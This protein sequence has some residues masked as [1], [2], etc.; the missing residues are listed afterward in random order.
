ML[1]FRI[2]STAAGPLYR[3]VS[4]QLMAAV[5]DGRL[6]PGQALPGEYALCEQL[7]VSRITIRRALDDLVE[8]GV[9]ERRRG[10]GTFVSEENRS[11]WRVKLTGILEDVL[12]PSDHEIVGEATREPPADVQRFARLSPGTSL[13][14]YE[15]TNRVG[16]APLVHISYYFPPAV[17]R[18]LSTKKLA[19]PSLVIDT[20][21][22]ALGCQV[23]FAEQIVEPMIATKAIAKA[24]GIA[25]GVAVLRAIRAYYDTTGRLIEILDAA[26]HPENYRYTATL[27]PRTRPERG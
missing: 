26:Y 22:R 11:A 2:P 25:A 4:E 12:T 20:V 21:Q 7:G 24:L 3:C 8:R 5:D 23:E 15:A 27:Y 16:G 13:K 14:V 19:G 18:H 10:I 17:A 9:L 6:K 1:F